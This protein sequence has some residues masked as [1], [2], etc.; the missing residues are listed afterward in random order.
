MHMFYRVMK[1]IYQFVANLLSYIPTKYYWNRSELLRKAKGW[2][3]FETQCIYKYSFYVYC[4]WMAQ[5]LGSHSRWWLVVPSDEMSSCASRS[6][7][8]VTDRR[9]ILACQPHRTKDLPSS[10]E[11]KLLWS[12]SQTLNLSATTKLRSFIHDYNA[13]FQSSSTLPS[14]ISSTVVRDVVS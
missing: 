5:V 6:R 4:W 10:I 1:G 8:S 2:T 13:S 12:S 9:L 7:T 3:F 14:N 11:R